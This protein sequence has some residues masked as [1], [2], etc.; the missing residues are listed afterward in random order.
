MLFSEKKKKFQVFDC[1]MK[2]ILKNIFMCLVIFWKYY[3]PTKFSHFL[4]HFPSNQT[5][6]ITENFK[7]YT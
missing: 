4:S 2:I 6:F 5:N 1:I 7:I 3:F